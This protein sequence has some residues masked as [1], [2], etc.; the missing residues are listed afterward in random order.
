MYLSLLRPQLTIIIS[1]GRDM[2][3]RSVP[4]GRDT[5]RSSPRPRGDGEEQDEQGFQV[6]AKRTIRQ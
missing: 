6:A 1:A 4:E 5:D 2:G 3:P